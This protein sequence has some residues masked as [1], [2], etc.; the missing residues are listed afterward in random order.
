MKKLAQQYHQLISSPKTR[1]F[2]FVFFVVIIFSL[3]YFIKIN[4][5]TQTLNP[6]TQ[7]VISTVIKNKAVKEPFPTP[8]ITIRWSDSSIKIPDS[9]DAYS[10]DK[11]LSSSETS[12]NIAE[13][14]GFNSSE[15]QN[16]SSNLS[17]WKKDEKTLLMNFDQNSI[18]YNTNTTPPNASQNNSEESYRT[19]TQEII[20]NIF[21]ESVA[22][23][24]VVQ[25]ISYFTRRSIYDIPSS[26]RD[27]NLIRVSLN[28]KIGDY[29]VV[30]L[31]E[32]GSIFTVFI[33][34]NLNLITFKVINGFTQ[35][36]VSQK[37]KTIEISKVLPL[38]ETLIQ[39]I[40]ASP[41]M[42]TGFD[43]ASAKSLTFDQSNISVAYYISGNQ[44]IPVY[45]LNG[46]VKITNVNDQ[47]GLYLLPAFY[48][49]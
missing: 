10:I 36:S 11:K 3:L 34:T 5:K 7:P 14:L 1:G 37:V 40:N 44:I 12:N 47:K 8:S 27:A 33:D 19:A 6:Q 21:G 31:S 18:T 35:A 2:V 38:A 15:R 9:L 30:T 41:D 46:T 16:K 28:Q 20:K 13:A 26:A 24:L 32:S 29:P 39:R 49:N 43:T 17:L 25:D 4:T 42:G 45:L 48:P 22:N 23:N